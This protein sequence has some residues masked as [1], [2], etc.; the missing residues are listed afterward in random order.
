MGLF[1]FLKDAG[2]DLQKEQAEL[3]ETREEAAKAKAMQNQITMLGLEVADLSVA[4]DDGTVT[5][6]GKAPNQAEREKVI[7]VLGNIQGVA[8]V[9]DQMTVGE[10]APEATM[11][12]VKSGDSLSG[13]A[14]AVY[15]DPMKYTAIFEANKPMLKDPNKIYPGQVLR[16]PVLDD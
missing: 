8:R 4:F 13:I 9:D 6:G 3:A 2:D 10:T 14:K 16:M 7:L 1:V 15:G 5:V 11:Y 12:T